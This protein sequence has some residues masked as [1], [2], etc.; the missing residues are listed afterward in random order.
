MGKFDINDLKNMPLEILLGEIADTDK[1]INLIKEDNDFKVDLLNYHNS[2]VK[3]LNEK[4]Q[5]CKYSN[6]N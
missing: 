1:K 6:Y 3:A 5:D 4:E 2:L